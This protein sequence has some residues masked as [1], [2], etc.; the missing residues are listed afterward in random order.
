[1]FEIGKM[2]HL[3]AVSLLAAL[4]TTGLACGN[5]EAA[6]NAAPTIV[7]DYKS[8]IVDLG[9][10]AATLEEFAGPPESS[11]GFS[12]GGP[13][14]AV[15]GGMIQVYEFPDTHAADTE[16]EYVSPDGYN[17]T[18]PLGGGRTRSTH[19]DWV[20]PPHYY[21]KGRVIVRYVGDSM[22]VQEVLEAVLGPQFAGPTTPTPTQAAP[23]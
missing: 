21:K 12:V 4:V 1:M 23:R 16:A 5:G 11:I 10:A 22:A 13:R 9:S 7:Y 14:V 8:L 6:P 17:I 18:V 2:E 3:I 15:N 19:S 20:A